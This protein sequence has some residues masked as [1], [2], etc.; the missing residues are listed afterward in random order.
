MDKGMV[1]VDISQCTGGS[2]DLGRY[3]T[4]RHLVEMGVLSGY[5]MTFEAAITKL[6]FLLG[7]DL[8]EKEL[9]VGAG[10]FAQR[11]H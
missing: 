6:M 1:I 9:K 11:T 3:E 10:R 5:D 2:V 7:Q 8:S 4:S